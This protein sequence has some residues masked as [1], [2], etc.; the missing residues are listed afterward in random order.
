MRSG[1]CVRCATSESPNQ[2]DRNGN[3]DLTSDDDEARCLPT[4]TLSMV[5][6]GHRE[7]GLVLAINFLPEKTS[8]G[9]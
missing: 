1:M 6:N 5:Y 3:I 4:C 7:F 2:E 9:H 8:P